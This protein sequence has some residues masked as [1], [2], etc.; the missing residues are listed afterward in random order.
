M[1]CRGNKSCF[2]AFL[3]MCAVACWGTEGQKVALLMILLNR[4]ASQ[5]VFGR[6][7][8]KLYRPVRLI[9]ESIPC[10][11]GNCFRRDRNLPKQGLYFLEWRKVSLY[12][13]IPFR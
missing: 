10:C 7:I 11:K 5:P 4:F 1:I 6:S 2:F 13:S 12:T 9:Y 3:R 8:D